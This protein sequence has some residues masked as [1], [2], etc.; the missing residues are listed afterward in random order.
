MG[1]PFSPSAALSA[2]SDASVYRLVS[3][4]R[5]IEI[6]GRLATFRIK[7]PRIFSRFQ[8]HRHFCDPWAK[9]HGPA[10]SVNSGMNKE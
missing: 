1:R 9:N 3:L 5:V 6:D 7:L 10:F 4:G 8:V 2:N